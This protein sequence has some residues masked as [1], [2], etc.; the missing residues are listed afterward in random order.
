MHDT[1]DC[2]SWGVLGAARIARRKAMPALMAAP[3]NRVVAL[4]SREGANA[5]EGVA[6]AM[7]VAGERGI[8][9]ERAPRAVAGY[10][11]LLDDPEVDAVYIPLPNHAHLEWAV[12]ALEAGKHVLLEKPAV[13]DG[14]QARTLAEAAARQPGLQVAEGFMF[15]HHPQWGVLRDW[16][17]AGRLGRLRS[18][19]VQFS[20]FSEDPE[21]IRNRP[22]TGGGA[23]LDIGCYAI[24]A[25]RL[26]F[27]GEPVRVRATQERVGGIDRHTRAELVFALP[28]GDTAELQFRA[29]IRGPFFQRL[30]LHGEAGRV[31]LERPFT[32]WPH[33]PV[34]PVFYDHRGGLVEHAEAVAADHFTLQAEAFAASVLDGAPLDFGMADLVAQADVLD[35]VRASAK[36]D[37]WAVRPQGG[38]RV[39]RPVSQP[40]FRP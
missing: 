14:A 7:A 40:G 9:P 16:L 25:G 11:A 21:N 20:F 4:A 2:L 31:V 15:R 12:R 13:L 22:E 30:D 35:A 29:D 32:P 18:A 28:D 8:E 1:D 19:V 38:V 3:R 26:I 27:G 23:L 5:A 10:E 34:A 33:D 36:A 17:E 37:A 6:E 39:P 24:A